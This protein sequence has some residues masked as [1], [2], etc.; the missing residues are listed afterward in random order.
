MPP[1]LA[2]CASREGRQPDRQAAS[3]DFFWKFWEFF[4]HFS[5]FFE[6]QGKSLQNSKLD[7]VSVQVRWSIEPKLWWE[8]LGVPC[9]SHANWYQKLSPLHKLVGFQTFSSLNKLSNLT[10]AWFRRLSLIFLDLRLLKTHKFVER[11][12]FLMPL[13][14]EVHVTP[15]CYHQ[16]FGSIAQRICTETTS[17]LNFGLIFLDFH[18]LVAGAT[19]VLIFQEI[20]RKFQACH[21]LGERDIQMPPLCEV[22]T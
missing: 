18:L 4:G 2:A 19:S 10:V 16:S 22:T 12:E 20:S 5:I 9:A 6:N 11:R 1:G 14:R 7:V 17:S 21:S 15:R 8:H 3:F 13:R